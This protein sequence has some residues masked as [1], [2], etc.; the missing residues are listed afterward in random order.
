MNR[1]VPWA[2]GGLASILAGAA[3]IT[4]A[5]GDPPD[6]ADLVPAPDTIIWAEGQESTVLV[7]TNR[8]DVDLRIN[9]VAMGI[10]NVM[11]AVPHS[12]ELMVLGASVGCQD[13]AVSKLTADSISTGGYTLKGNIDRDN[14]TSTAEVHYRTRVEGDDEWNPGVNSPIAVTYDSGNIPDS[15]RFAQPVT[16]DEHVWEV[17]ASSDD[18]FP[19]ALTRFITID[20]T[21]RPAG[22]ATTDEEAESIVLLRDTGIGLKACSEHDDVVLTLHGQEGVELNRYVVDIGQ[23]PADRPPMYAGRRVCLDDGGLR[24]DYLTGDERVGADFDSTDFGLTGDVVSVTLDDVEAGN[25]FRFFFDAEI[26]ADN[27]RLEVSEAGAG[28]T[29]GLNTD[30]IYPVRVTATD[31]G[32]ASAYLDVGVWLDTALAA[33]GDG[34]CT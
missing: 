6:Y 14:F 31:A 12:G 29:L 4:L 30:R 23:R 24:S 21:A 27:V 20:M 17:E 32:G 15:N 16:A 18:D 5:V 33:N 2:V 28:D 22:T 7:S 1:T 8:D 13:W 11:G 3:L 34:L 9:S 25:D 10:S 26:V 19:V